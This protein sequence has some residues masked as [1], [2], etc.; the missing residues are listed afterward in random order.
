MVVILKEV[1][2]IQ[3]KTFYRWANLSIHLA[4]MKDKYGENIIISYIV[5]YIP[6]MP[7]FRVFWA[8][9][10]QVLV[11]YS[12][13]FLILHD[14][15]EQLAETILNLHCNI[16]SLIYDTKVCNYTINNL[17]VTMISWFFP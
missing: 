8:P 9:E 16:V 1:N 10:F 5:T 2:L 17:I 13:C 7:F 14:L 3:K 6:Q 12:Y 11:S 15:L 4:I